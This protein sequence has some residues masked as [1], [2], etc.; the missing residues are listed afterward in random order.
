MHVLNKS[1]DSENWKLY[2]YQQLH[3]SFWDAKGRPG[4]RYIL[5]HLLTEKSTSVSTFRLKHKSK[6]SLVYV[7]HWN[8]AA[9][10][11]WHRKYWDFR[12]H[13]E[14]SWTQVNYR[15]SLINSSICS[16]SSNMCCLQTRPNASHAMIHRHLS[17]CTVVLLCNSWGIRTSTKQYYPQQLN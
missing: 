14:C 2:Y 11:E 3:D 17:R 7:P 9:F 10:Y 15:K 1:I 12:T 8:S 16:S 4:L 6:R 5:N 13:L